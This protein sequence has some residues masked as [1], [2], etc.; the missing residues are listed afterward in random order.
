M[1]DQW[2]SRSP[3]TGRVGAWPTTRPTLR[4]ACQALERIDGAVAVELADG[5]F[6]SGKI[7][8]APGT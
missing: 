5:S 3:L 6:M 8:V 1:T 7:I 4:S 2:R